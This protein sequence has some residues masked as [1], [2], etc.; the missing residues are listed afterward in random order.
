[1][2]NEDIQRSLGRIEGK[3]ETFE[4]GINDRLDRMD[5]RLDKLEN[6]R[7]W[8]YQWRVYAALAGG[9]GTLGGGVILGVV[10]TLQML[11]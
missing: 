8:G 11:E 4:E 6:Q 9:S 7:S 1:M 2:Q 5:N 10:K 3:F